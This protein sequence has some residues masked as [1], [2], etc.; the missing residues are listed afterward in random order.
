MTSG[1]DTVVLD[2]RGLQFS[3]EQAR[4]ERVLGRRPGVL[5]VDAN[6]VAQTATV[7]FDELDDV[8]GRAAPA[9]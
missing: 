4:V 3:S 1:A 7:T 2:V 9:G 6:P 5:A 8:A